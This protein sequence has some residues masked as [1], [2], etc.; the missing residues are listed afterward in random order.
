M[1]PTN[2]DRP[3][4]GRKLV[5]FRGPFTVLFTQVST[6]N[7]T[8]PLITLSV[9]EFVLTYRNVAAARVIHSGRIY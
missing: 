2:I 3:Q 4:A 7:H 8:H 5:H 9:Y 1:V 6:N